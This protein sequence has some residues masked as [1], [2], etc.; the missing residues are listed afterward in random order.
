MHSKSPALALA[1][2]AAGCVQELDK[3]TGKVA[4]LSFK[5]EIEGE[6]GSE[7]SP[8]AYSGTGRQFLLDIRAVDDEGELATWFSGQVNIDVAPRGRLAPNQP[9]TVTLKDGEARGVPV[10][11]MRAHGATNIWVEDRGSDEK[12][13]SYATGLSPTIHVAHPTLREINETDIPASSPLDGDFVKVNAEGRTLVVTG[14]AV[15]GFYLTDMNDMAAGFNAIFAHTHSRPKGVEQGSVIEE[16]IGTVVEFYGFTELGFPTY[17]VGGKVS[18]LVPVELTGALVEQDGEMEK[19]ESR[20]VEVRDVTVCPL[21]DGYATF[22]QWVVLVDPAGNC[23]SGKGGVNV[24]SAL[25]ATGFDPADHAGGKLARITG[26]L[27]FHAA[28]NP[29]W[30]IYTRGDEDIEVSAQ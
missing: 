17:R 18:N 15:D 7:K 11:V 22:G 27:R 24:V 1:L 8:L 30:L 16:I 5:V 13:G 14:I 4:P 19:L 21:G 20:L 6:V 26:D 28:A 10:E 2:L 9:N 25:S 12:P 23:N 29:S 3:S